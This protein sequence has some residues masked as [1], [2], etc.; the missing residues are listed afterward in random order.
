[1]IISKIANN[2]TTGNYTF[3]DYIKAG[4][5][6]CLSIGIDFTGSNG[7]PL[8]DGTLHCIKG[9]TPNDYERAIRYCGDIVS[10]YDYDQL[11]PV[12]GFGAIVNSSY[13]KEASMC[14]NINFLDNPDILY[15][16]L[17]QHQI[18]HSQ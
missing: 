4:V 2:T 1:M 12:Y 18:N 16:L 8:D 17:F 14:F 6:I 10:Y 13:N 9:K 11:I 7:H 5:R 15:I 3:L